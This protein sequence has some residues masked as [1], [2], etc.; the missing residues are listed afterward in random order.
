M[1]GSQPA[2]S[3]SFRFFS[4]TLISNPASDQTPLHPL[5]T[6]HRALRRAEETVGHIQQKHTVRA[7]TS[8]GRSQ[9]CQGNWVEYLADLRFNSH[10]ETK[11][12]ST[13]RNLQGVKSI[14]N[15]DLTSLLVVFLLCTRYALHSRFIVTKWV[16]LNLT[17][18][19]VEEGAN[20]TLFS[21]VIFSP[22]CQ[23]CTKEQTGLQAPIWK[24]IRH[25]KYMKTCHTRMEKY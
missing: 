3:H 1:A 5:S 10:R 14:P 20:L 6:G 13:Q 16:F 22:A 21:E 24:Q 25:S 15:R 7:K 18:D 8:G 9:T 19:F 12:F 2:R 4:V 17:V 11:C 23:I